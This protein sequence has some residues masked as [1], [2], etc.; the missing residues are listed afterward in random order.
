MSF[1]SAIQPKEP[2]SKSWIEEKL[3]AQ[4]N[5]NGYPAKMYRHATTNLV[6]ISAVEVATELD[7]HSN[8]PEFHISISKSS[9]Y[10]PKRCTSLEANE[11]IKVFGAEGAIEDNHVPSG[12]VRNFWLPVAENLIGHQCPC[13]ER[14]PKVIEDKGDYVWRGITK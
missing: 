12:K 2:K 6:V 10:G 8:G 13:V 4:F 5:N 3:P 9:K 11:V 14:E 1:L 7:G